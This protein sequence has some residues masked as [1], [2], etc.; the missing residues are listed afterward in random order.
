MRPIGR[1]KRQRR[2]RNRKRRPIN[3]AAS[4][5]TT[6]SLYA[7][8]AAIFAAINQRFDVAAYWIIGAMF[9]DT[10]DGAVA[11]FTNSV[12]DFGKELDSL[13]DVVSFGV[14]PAVMVYIAY[15]RG[16]D[17]TSGSSA[18]IASMV[19]I[20]FVIC[21]A[22]RL[23]RY[24][25]YQSGRR[26]YFVGLPIPAAGGTLAAMTLFLEYFQFEHRA[27]IMGPSTLF[28]AGLMVSTVRYPREKMRLF[29]LSPRHAFRFLV[30]VV[31]GIAAF[32]YASQY[33]PAI[34]LMPLAV[35]YVLF[36]VVDE[37]LLRIRRLS[38]RQ[39]SPENEEDSARDEE[40]TAPK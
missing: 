6:F 16:I 34:I 7:G 38:R 29:I 14:A 32:H 39:R 25:V 15:L 2:K 35:S 12:S 11:R 1:T 13:C 19:A 23:A 40:L 26:D 9:L 24:N 5:I 20:I 10:L 21:G 33:S 28:L 3:V 30:L 27:L 22:L 17:P 37:T 8:L 4:V 36:G 18:P 31:I